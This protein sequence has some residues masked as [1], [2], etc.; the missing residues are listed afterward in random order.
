MTKTLEFLQVA[1]DDV[2]LETQTSDTQAEPNEV[3]DVLFRFVNT[4]VTLFN[5][6]TFLTHP[7]I[8][9]SVTPC[10]LHC[11]NSTLF[12][13][14]A[15]QFLFQND[16]TD[17]IDIRSIFLLSSCLDFCTLAKISSLTFQFIPS[18]RQ[19]LGIWADLPVK[20]DEE[21]AP[22][23]VRLIRLL[24]QLVLFDSETVVRENLGVYLVPHFASLC[25]ISS[26]ADDAISILLLLSSTRTGKEYLRQLETIQY[27]LPETKRQMRLWQPVALLLT[28]NDFQQP[29]IFKRLIYL[30]N[31]RTI[32]IFQ[33]LATATNDTS[34]D[35]TTPSTKNQMALAAIEWIELL[36]T[37]F[38]VYTT[39]VDEFISSAKKNNFLNMFID[40]IL[41]LEQ[42]EDIIPKL[43]D[44]LIELLWTLTLS[45][46]TSIHEH[47]QKR[48]DLYRW[49]KSNIT[50]GT[51]TIRL[52][53]QA[54]LSTFDF[55]ATQR[56]PSANPTV[57]ICMFNA[58]SNYSQ[59]CLTLRD[60]IQ[61]ERQYS[62]ELVLTPVCQTIDSLLHLINRSSVCLFC[63]TS[64]MKSDNLSHFI[65]RYLT[66]QSS[67]IPLFTILLERE[68]QVDGTWLLNVPMINKR[69]IL[70][71]VR[72]QL[73][74]TEN[75][76]LRASSRGSDHL[77]TTESHA[78]QAI[79]D[80]FQSP[81][82]HFQLAPV[83]HWTSDD[84]ADWCE[85]SKGSFDSLQ[86]LMVRLNGPSLMHLAEILA[87]EPAS[88]YY[89]L[90]DELIQRTGSSVPLTEYVS[91]SS[92]LQ[93]L[94]MQRENQSITTSVVTPSADS[95]RKSRRKMNRFCTLF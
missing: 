87:I 41:A 84:V 35:S 60:Q 86:P 12:I 36:R 50:D 7:A 56:R 53:S 70:K 34:F 27:V 39:I 58:D 82:R 32:S 71:H 73:N 62:V 20:T 3:T 47:L 74:G 19:I 67:R 91:L 55:T 31:Q 46:S 72:R 15:R 30:L 17:K 64:R 38:L 11:L 42:E 57:L 81:S 93:R 77:S 29:N 75:P 79:N 9:K 49:L 76:P 26:V 10:I 61:T 28:P 33:S 92:E 48:V 4:V 14:L 22:L 78:D 40:T 54:I 16:K 95:T 25:Q 63:V 59:L 5:H 2:F 37:N 44:E 51:P 8:D 89:R 94:L 85:A 24:Y 18:I 13:R 66:V 65:Y 90:N 21:I 83:A 68:C 80:D 43:I 52:A 45:S 23:I 1:A 69:S 88:M 6:R